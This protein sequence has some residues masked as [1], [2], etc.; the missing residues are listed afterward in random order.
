MA[1][2][3][4][5]SAPAGHSDSGLLKP[6]ANNACAVGLLPYNPG[7]RPATRAGLSHASVGVRAAPA[8]AAAAAHTT[9]AA[10]DTTADLRLWA[11]TTAKR[12][13]PHEIALAAAGLGAEPG[14]AARGLE[15][16]SG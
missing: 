9:D 11:D 10:A 14:P 7:G 15:Q 4:R 5:L 13:A 3:A 8:A 6:P 1:P 2:P 16:R 12:V